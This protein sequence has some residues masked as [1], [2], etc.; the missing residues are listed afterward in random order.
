MRT[1][2]PLLHFYYSKLPKA[3]LPKAQD[4]RTVK[5]ANAGFSCEAFP[6]GKDNSGSGGT[7]T[8]TG[9]SNAPITWNELVKYNETNPK[10]KIF[11]ARL[12]ELQSQF[13]G[14]TSEQLLAS[15][16]DSARIKQ[17]MSNLPRYDQPS[18]QTYDK[19]Y[20]Q[21][22]RT[23]MNQ[24]TPVTTPQIL[25]FQSQ[26][27][28]GLP[29]YKKVVESNYGR[30][31]AQDGYNIPKAQVGRI[32]PPVF[33][34]FTP[35]MLASSQRSADLSRRNTG[36]ASQDAYML[37]E[38]EMRARKIQQAKQ[39]AIDDANELK[40]RRDA[41]ARSNNSKGFIE[42]SQ[43]AAAGDK[44]RFFPN[45]PNSFIDD[46][47]NPLKMIG[48]MGDNIGRSFTREDA[49]FGD[50]ALSIGTPLLM[51]A[52]GFDPLGAGI[53]ATQH[54]LVSTIPSV[55]RHSAYAPYGEALF[56]GAADRLGSVAANIP[57]VNQL[58][59]KAAENMAGQGSA[60]FRSLKDIKRVF[61]STSNGQKYTGLI[62]AA[63][64]DPIRESGR[65]LVR[66]Y[67]YGDAKGFIPSNIPTQGLEEYAKRYGP[68]KTYKLDASRI[69]DAPMQI[70]KFLSRYGSD[71]EKK[72][73]INNMMRPYEKFDAIKDYV[74]NKG[75]ISIPSEVN[76]MGVDDIA[77][78][79]KFLNYNP[80]TDDI[81]MK[82]QDIW[83]FIPKDYNTR[84][85]TGI[86]RFIPSDPINL[87]NYLK[88][89]SRNKQVSLMERS[90]KPFVL[91]D[92]RPLS[93]KVDDYRPI[94]TNTNKN[95][96]E[97][98][99]EDY[100][101]AIKELSDLD[102]ENLMLTEKNRFPKV[103]EILKQKKEGGLLNRTITCPNCG[104]SWKSVDA[105]ADLL[106]CHK[107][108]GMA[109]LKHG[110]SYLPKTQVGKQIKCPEGF[111]NIDGNCIEKKSREY[112]S[113]LDEGRVGTMK[114]D[115]WYGNK[116]ELPPVTVYASKD[117]DTQ[118]FY[119]L[120]RQKTSQ[121]ENDALLGLLDQYPNPK[122][123]MHSKPKFLS[124]KFSNGKY[125]PNY[126]P[127]T[128]RI[129]LSDNPNKLVSDYISELAHHKQLYKKGATDFILNATG[130]IIKNTPDYEN[131]YYEEGNFEHDAHENIEPELKYF[132]WNKT[133]KK[134]WG[135]DAYEYPGSYFKDHPQWKNFKKKSGGTFLPKAQVGTINCPVGYIKDENGNCVPIMSRNQQQAVSDET[136]V[137]RRDYEGERASN[138]RKAVASQPQLKQ[139]RP[140]T[141]YEAEVRKYKNK[142]AVAKNPNAVVN[143]Q[144]YIVP[145]YADTD[146][147][148]RVINRQA[149]IQRRMQG[150]AAGIAS[151]FVGAAAVMGAG[152]AGAATIPYIA[153]A[154]NA[155][156]LGTFGSQYGTGALTLN[157]L[158]NAGFAYKGAQ[159]IPNVGRSIQT[160]YN[161][162]TLSNIGNAAGEF[163]ITALDMLPFAASSFKGIPSVMQ[164]VNQAGNWMNK[165]IP[166]KDALVA[167]MLSKQLA[168]GKPRINVQRPLINRI[169]PINRSS[170]NVKNDF[171]N[172]MNQ[173]EYDELI[174]NVYDNVGHAYDR[175]FVEF[176][177]SRPNSFLSGVGTTPDEG[178]DEAMLLKEKF[179]APG[180]ECA[181]T[182]NAVTNR[183]YTDITGKPFDAVGNAHNAWHM[184]DQMTR[185][186]GMN[187]RGQVPIKVG[188]RVLMGNDVNQS[189]YVPGFTADPR[190]RHAGVFA[191]MSKTES[192]DIFP[193]I[194][195]SGQSN[196]LYLN[197]LQSTFTG[198]NTVVE[199]IRPNQFLDD[200]F[201][202]ALV[203]KNIR[204]AFRDKPPVANFSSDN[205][206][207]QKLL[208]D[209]EPF[210]ET[211]KR[212][213]DITNDEFNELLN[214][215]V[216]IG[217]QETKLNGALPGSKL[218]KAK[219][220]LQNTL[221]RYGLIK[222][223]KQGLNAVKQT[224]NAPASSVNLPKFPGNSRIEMEAA[225]FAKEN[226]VPFESAVKQI[227]SQYQPQSRFSL[228]TVE[229]SKGMFRQKYQTETDRLSNFGGDLKN[230]NSLEN[231]LGQMSEN[232]NKVKNIYP[233][234]TPRQLM[235]ITTLM[236]NSPGKAMNKQLVDFYVFGKNNPDPSKFNFDYINKINNIKNKYIN[237]KPQSV[238]PHL[239]LLQ[240]GKY[241]IIQY[242]KGG[243]TNT[244]P[245]LNYYLQ[246]TG[247]KK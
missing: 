41:I 129:N 65:N 186:G 156:L 103:N 17:R 106:T 198:P 32:T 123:S 61:N 126:N 12:K 19:A 92:E 75:S 200:T 56:Y 40:R 203:D 208:T 193:M 228:S 214:S 20:H 118:A 246:K 130:D 195:E 15:Q 79:M 104:H 173:E 62:G 26:Q 93:I 84:Y 22:Y 117:K 207:V 8:A 109:K 171:L 67:I 88:T 220:Q 134:K 237:V 210:R 45:D 243:V 113:L 9:F 139:G 236:W 159:N 202:K 90:G 229:P 110:G 119:D 148:G 240:N 189:T 136:R 100:Q 46:Y 163:G 145:K 137:A 162:P 223:I 43:N 218:A 190:V 107:C 1:D 222:P 16:G 66:N 36:Y 192:G 70:N 116:A 144:G 188:D 245:L 60:A 108:G 160:A 151:P 211:I 51:G 131:L 174:Q 152:A 170:V 153:P 172:E 115:M 64:D 3:P 52:L 124:P 212:T 78:H 157:N 27:P 241:P 18:E 150:A 166:G 140:E 225:I 35:E 11:K 242:G 77:G 138:F 50:K 63:S 184:E 239:Q 83:K 48:D 72:K 87:S 34:G 213:H 155:P 135:N 101:S 235:D 179:C 216:S 55:L 132:Y 142:G 161:D 234:A 37:T 81:M 201:G 185:S 143:E 23:M 164:D 58:Y 76:E 94:N 215:L 141:Q 74:K 25:Q 97:L 73:I 227:K 14:L 127:F 180:S 231:A 230:K 57:G 68:L 224:M 226:N 71:L 169:D 54:P 233:D 29:G 176:K 146:E 5:A 133:Q 33:K 175:P 204:Y 206:A 98:S 122:V 182:A 221:N 244:N 191:G 31:R 53:K 158:I 178:F 4:A 49:T 165:N 99:K 89:Y 187:L 217:G 232:Y 96:L 177:S 111:I 183:M 219:I 205:Q 44:L 149:N 168:F 38:N 114:G 167:G 154:L 42:Q 59:K 112:K 121:E 85:G 82:T 238:S 147:Y 120:L 2:S 30:P 181:K 10:D 194:F 69:E 209:A 47:L 7:G 86:D 24:I 125:R 13:P 128:Q 6:R 197:P 28:G 95:I 199:V 80:T 91:V 39:K 247:N 105:G 102:L 21:F 196:P